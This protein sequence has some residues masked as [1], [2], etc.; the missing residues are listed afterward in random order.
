MIG[1]ELSANESANE[2]VLVATDFSDVSGGYGSTATSKSDR[3]GEEQTSGGILPLHEHRSS[4][5]YDEWLE[6]KRF[7]N[8]TPVFGGPLRCW[9]SAQE[10]CVFVCN[11]EDAWD[12][13]DPEGSSSKTYGAVLFWLAVFAFAY[14]MERISFKVLVDR[15]RPFRVVSAEAISIVHALVLVASTL[16]RCSNEKHFEWSNIGLPLIDIGRE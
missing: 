10:C 7:R 3:V 1:R 8:C 6:R 4:F 15:I 14:A 9:K 16:G 2:S 13:P 5:L 11:I 12:T